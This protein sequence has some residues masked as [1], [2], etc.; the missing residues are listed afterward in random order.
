MSCCLNSDNFEPDAEAAPVG[1]TAQAKRWT[2]GLSLPVYRQKREAGPSPSSPLSHHRSTPQDL[3]REL[4][5]KVE[6]VDEERYDIEAKC[7]H[8]TREVSP[9]GVGM[10][11]PGLAGVDIGV[12]NGVWEAISQHGALVFHPNTLGLE[13]G[14][15]ESNT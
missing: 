15:K 2:I 14:R 13:M 9:G 5:A 6:V 1:I 12:A 10:R 4:H 8:N 3:C 7:L 11:Q